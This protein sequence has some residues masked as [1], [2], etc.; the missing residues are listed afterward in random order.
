[1]TVAATID[2]RNRQKPELF[3]DRLSNGGFLFEL[4]GIYP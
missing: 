1:M 2:R 4:P 3:E